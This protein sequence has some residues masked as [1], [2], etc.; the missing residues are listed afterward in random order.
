[1]KKIFTKRKKQK[2]HNREEEEKDKE[3]AK[4]Q[5]IPNK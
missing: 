4:S 3:T 5:I 1:M 2:V